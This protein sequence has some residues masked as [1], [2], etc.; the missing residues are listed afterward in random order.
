MPHPNKQLRVKQRNAR[1]P[2]RIWTCWCGDASM[3]ASNSTWEDCGRLQLT[4]T[5]MVLELD[6]EEVEEVLRVT[7][8]A[9]AFPS[10]PPEP[11]SSSNRR[12]ITG[13]C[14]EE[15]RR[16]PVGK[17]ARVVWISQ[18]YMT[19]SRLFLP[20][21]ICVVSS[22]RRCQRWSPVFCQAEPWLSRPTPGWPPGWTGPPASGRTPGEPGWPNVI[23]PASRCSMRPSSAPSME[24]QTQHRVYKRVH[25]NKTQIRSG[26]MDLHS[27]ELPGQTSRWSWWHRR[28]TVSHGQRSGPCGWAGSRWSGGETVA[29][30]EGP[31]PAAERWRETF[32]EWQKNAATK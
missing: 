19:P 23:P 26:Q 30:W 10:L 12:P 8:M 32:R 20:F 1:H 13:V 9:L 29:Y 14:Q 28:W 24:S 27:L 3:E 6:P 4:G 18:T 7:A 16:G 17:N 21:D 31:Y 25:H 22:P 5:R 11:W 15:Q 2:W